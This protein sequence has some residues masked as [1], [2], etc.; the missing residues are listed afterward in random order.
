MSASVER[1]IEYRP[2][3]GY[4]QL[5]LLLLWAAT[6]TSRQQPLLEATQD[7]LRFGAV[8]QPIKRFAAELSRGFTDIAYPPSAGD[9]DAESGSSNKVCERSGGRHIQR[10]RDSGVNGVIYSKK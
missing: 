6:P 10:N 8:I 4:R 5:L 3:A 7:G 1:Q 9:S 2:S